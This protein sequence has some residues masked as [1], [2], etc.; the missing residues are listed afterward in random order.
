MTVPDRGHAEGGHGDAGHAGLRTYLV[1]AGIL[2][3]VTALEFA[4]LYI[5]ALTPIVVP[6][7]LVM[8]AG[9]FALVV[10]F[11]MHLRYDHRTLWWVF[12]GAL[13]VATGLVVALTTLTGAFLVYRR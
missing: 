10:L 5:R 3:V 7:L 8:S 13:V 9:K 12:G 11:F 4:V 6:L 2:T 1:V